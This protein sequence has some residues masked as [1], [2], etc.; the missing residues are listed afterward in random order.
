[1][2]KIKLQLENV[3]KKYRTNYRE[4]LALDNI[5]INFQEGKFYAIM[6]H[7]GSGKSTL[8]NIIGLLDNITSGNYFINGKNIK[9]LK[10]KDLANLRK[11][12]F[13]FVFQDFYLDE[14]LKAYENVMFPMIINK[15]IPKKERKEK[16]YKLLNDLGL[17]DRLNHF[18]KE[19]SG[20]ERQRVAIARSLA[21]NPKVILADEPTGDLD[22][23]NEEKIFSILKDLSSQGKCVIVVSHSEKVK[24][25]ADE[26][27]YIDYGK[28]EAKN[29]KK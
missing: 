6:G 2:E 13:G 29:D 18:P 25:Y 26:I 22:A 19:L 14:Y 9:D 27:Y 15:N 7:S 23:D 3:T 12:F 21:N 8:I 17:N 4:I 11:E 28:I 10:E 1:M 20:G 24:E 16:A 5:N